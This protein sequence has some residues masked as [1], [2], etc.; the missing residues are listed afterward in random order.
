M[1]KLVIERNK[2][3]NYNLFNRIDYSIN[4]LIYKKLTFSK[5]NTNFLLI[6]CDGQNYTIFKY[7]IERKE[8]YNFLDNYI[9]TI[10][11]KISFFH[12]KLYSFHT[13]IYIYNAIFFFYYNILKKKQLCI[14]KNFINLYK[15]NLLINKKKRWN[16]R[17][18]IW[19]LLNNFSFF[20]KTKILSNFSY[21]K[22]T[23]FI[24]KFKNIINKSFFYLKY[25]TKKWHNYVWYFKK[26]KI[27]Q[28]LGFKDIIERKIYAQKPLFY[29]RKYLTIVYKTFLYN[30]NFRQ[31]FEIIKHLIIF[32]TYLIIKKLLRN[33]KNKINLYYKMR[34]LYWKKKYK[35]KKKFYKILVKKLW[36]INLLYIANIFLT[37]LFQKYL[38]YIFFSK[39]FSFMKNK[40]II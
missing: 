4:D 19:I 11:N 23:F 34:K 39:K 3:K 22:R 13:N 7:I 12:N 21:I 31:S 9:L 40:S 32:N 35:K 37:F 2:K 1:K 20:F 27:L 36:K 16:I 8:N 24:I 28:I 26:K 29:Y 14:K 25:R 38:L 17:N 6:W 30:Y 15:I 18:N 5:H 10:N 33:S